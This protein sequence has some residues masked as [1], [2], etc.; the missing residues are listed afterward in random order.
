MALPVRQAQAEGSAVRFRAVERIPY[1]RNP[2]AEGIQVLNLYIP[3]AYLE[4]RKVGPFSADQAPFFVLNSVGGYR[5]GLAS[6]VEGPQ[7]GLILA[8]LTEGCVVA[9]P[10]LRGRELQD[11]QGEFLGKAP[12]AIVDLKAAIR[13]LRGWAG[14][15]PGCPERVICHGMSAGG[16]LAALAGASGDHPVYESHLRK[17]GALP[18]SDAVFAV[19]AYCPITDLEHADAA[20]EWLFCGVPPVKTQADGVS[21]EERYRHSMAL[22]ASFPDYLNSLGLV[23][24]RGQ[25]LTLDPEGQGPFLDHLSDLVVASAQAALDDGLALGGVPWLRIAHGRVRAVDFRGLL[26]ALGRGK[27]APVYDGLCLE[28]QAN[29]LFG[30]SRESARHFTA[31]GADQGLRPGTTVN[32]ETVAMMNP[33]AFLGRKGGCCAPHWR[34]RHGLEDRHLFI[35][36]ASYLALRLQNLGAQVDFAL[37]WGRG[38][39]ACYD[40]PELFQWIREV[41]V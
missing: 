14:L 41:C 10:G 23:G 30:S 4:G 34:M 19:S 9:A 40:L 39:E 13:C 35:A 11:G 15:L 25:R 24:P 32:P 12:A 38:H 31:Y 1:V 22:R 8:A 6:T 36:V 29:G 33:M 28:G 17:M 2:M 3:E 20:Y 16:A 27:P 7:G 37:P 26:L 18:G 5:S 21:E